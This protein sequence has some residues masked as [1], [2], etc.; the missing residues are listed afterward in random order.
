MSGGRSR[1][2][3]RVLATSTVVIQF[4]RY[5]VHPHA[6][7]NKKGISKVKKLLR[8]AIYTRLAQNTCTFRFQQGM[9]TYHQPLADH[10]EPSVV[11]WM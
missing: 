7:K 5:G 4:L 9:G 3:R 11:T 2:F 1:R 6:L 10:L 8:P